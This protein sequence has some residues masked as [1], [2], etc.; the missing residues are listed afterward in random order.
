MVILVPNM[1]KSIKTDLLFNEF[2]LTN[3]KYIFDLVQ[4][5]N[6]ENALDISITCNTKLTLDSSLK[7]TKIPSYY[8]RKLYEKY[9][10][11]VNP[12]YKNL[13]YIEIKWLQNHI[14]II[15]IHHSYLINKVS[16][17][18]NF[19]KGN[20]PKIVLTLRGSDTYV[21]PWYYKAWKHYYKAYMPKMD[22]LI[23]QSEHQK[24]Y[25]KTVW[26]IEEQ[27]IHV[28]P[29]SIKISTALPKKR[30]EDTI[31]IVSSFRMCWEKNIEGNIRV[32]RVLVDKGYNVK[33]D[34]FGYGQDLGQVYYLVDKFNLKNHINIK[35][36]IDNSAYLEALKNYDFY[37]QL[38]IVESLSISVIEAQ[39]KG[40]PAI[41]S[42]SSGILETIKPN[43]SGF[44]V[45]YY[46]VGMAAEKIIDL[47]NN[48][49]KYFEFS[50]E[51]IQHVNSKYTNDVESEKHLELYKKLVEKE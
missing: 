48:H 27:L 41:V 18:L 51:A 32:I 10:R 16:N 30:L 34:V 33:Y 12:K 23:V 44:A 4:K 42:D 36:K 7:I 2:P 8:Y 14:N 49:S 13:S 46:D 38:S 1:K 50:T 21:K 5:L 15:H 6:G 40:I 31:K 43:E 25:L 17:L 37:L 39:S 19:K 9:I 35:G 24:K 3:Q 47:V 45:P 26:K 29:S 20:R 22:A 28:I 11:L